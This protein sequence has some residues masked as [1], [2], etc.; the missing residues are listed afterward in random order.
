MHSA[1]LATAFV[2]VQQLCISMWNRSRG[3]SYYNL[4]VTEG[5]AYLSH[6]TCYSSVHYHRFPA[7]DT[8]LWINSLT[9]DSQSCDYYI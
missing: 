8:A 3:L 7:S 1:I 6:G 5:F 2:L 9:M 4:R